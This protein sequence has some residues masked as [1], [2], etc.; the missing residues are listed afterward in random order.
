[1]N[2]SGWIKIHR[3]MLDWEWYLD[4]NIVRLFIHLLLKANWE[5][6]KWCGILIKRGSFVTSHGSLSEETKLSIQQ[7]R[8]CLSKLKLTD[9]ILIKST[10]KHTLK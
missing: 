6:K 7:I 8:T 1:M 9:E 2:D 4:S 3:N 10:N 5:D